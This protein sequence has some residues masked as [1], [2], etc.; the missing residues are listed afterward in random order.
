LLFKRCHSEF[1]LEEKGQKQRTKVNSSTHRR[2]IIYWM[3]IWY[4][5]QRIGLICSLWPVYTVS[6]SS[7]YVMIRPLLSLVRVRFNWEAMHAAT[8]IK[9]QLIMWNHLEISMK[10][11]NRVGK[12]IRT[13]YFTLLA[14]STIT[15]PQLLLCFL[16]CILY[17]LFY[18]KIY[19]IYAFICKI[20]QN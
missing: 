11:G 16:V 12:V 17:Y 4:F 8:P 13:P 10:M 5:K 6:N 18:I 7:G 9:L 14:N 1:C 20:F 19:Y 3:R 15:A 2:P